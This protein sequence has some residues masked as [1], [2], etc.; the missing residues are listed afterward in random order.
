MSCVESEGVVSV[1]SKSAPR[2]RGVEVPRLER[3]T[4]FWAFV[5][6]A[7]APLLAVADEEELCADG[8]ALE[9]RAADEGIAVE[10]RKCC[11]APGVLVATNKTCFS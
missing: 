4:G 6:G 8:Y 9:E 10:S 5:L 3:V 7:A 11:Q 1:V 2:R